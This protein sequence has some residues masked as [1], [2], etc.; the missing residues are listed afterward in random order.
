MMAIQKNKA[1]VTNS[2][3]RKLEVQRA[4]ITVWI[5][6]RQIHVPNDQDE[7]AGLLEMKVILNI[8]FPTLIKQRGFRDYIGSI[9][10]PFLVV[11]SSKV[12][13]RKLPSG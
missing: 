6:D 12:E 8:K 11:K 1:G 3:P 9:K 7:W 2:G 10:K 5:I 13:I 4:K